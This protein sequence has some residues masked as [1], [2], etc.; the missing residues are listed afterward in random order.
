MENPGASVEAERESG[1]RLRRLLLV[2]FFL[3]GA[4]ALIYQVVWVRMLGLVFGVTSIAVTTVLAAF[5]AG[6]ALGSYVGGRF[7]DRRRD[8]LRIFGFLQ[9]GIGLFAILLP[10]CLEGL[11]AVYVSVYRSWPAD[12]YVFSLMRF[13]LAFGLLL[14]PTSL[15][16][17]TLPVLAR[18]FVRGL[19]E[20]GSGM[21][22]LYSVNNWGAVVG[23]LGAGFVCLELFG[24][25][26]TGWLAAALSIGVGLVAFHLH[27]RGWSLEAAPAGPGEPKEPSPSEPEPGAGG[28]AGLKPYPGYVLVLVLV[29]FGIEGFTSLG[30]EVVWTRILS[31]LGIVT[32]VYT[33]SLVVATFIAGLAIGSFLAGKYLDGRGDPLTLLAVIEVGIGLSAALL[34]PVFNMMG[35]RLAG[36]GVGGWG[37]LVGLVA[38]WTGLLLLVP[39]TLMGA[40]FPLVS[41]IYT[42]NFRELGRRIGKIGC[43]DTVG[44]IFG[45]FAGGFLLIPFVGMHR[46]VLFLA[47]LNVAIG[48]GLLLCHPR[49]RPRWKGAWTAGIAAVGLG[50]LLFLPHEAVFSPH[51]QVPDH[52]V[53]YDEGID[54]TVTVREV[55]HGDRVLE[56]NHTNVAGTAPS[57]VSTQVFQGHMPG[58]IYEALNGRRPKRGLTIGLGTGHTAWCLRQHD[59]EEIHCVE[60]VPGVVEAAKEHFRVLHHGI[61][62]DPRF[63]VSVQD[64]R[65]VL[66]ATDRKYD[67]ILDDAVHPCFGGNA[68]L[69]TTDFFS[70]CRQRL[71]EGGVMT[72]WLPI[73]KLRPDDLRMVLNS[74][75]SVFPHASV[76]FAPRVLN[77]HALLVGTQSEL[78]LDLQTLRRRLTDEAVRPAL[79][80]IGLVNVEALVNCLLLD[81]EG[82]GEFS[83]DAPLHTDNHPYLAFSAPRARVLGPAA[84][85]EN[86]SL[87]ARH[88]A[89]IL[90]HLYHLGQTPDEAA[91]LRE[92]IA[93]QSEATEHLLEGLALH[94]TGGFIAAI[95]EGE[96]ALELRP[97]AP[98][99]R[100][101]L[102]TAHADRAS[103]LFW[104]DRRVGDAFRECRKSLKYDPGNARAATL[105]A[106][107]LAR[108][109]RLEHAIQRLEAGLESSPRYVPA[110]S[111]LAECYARVGALQMARRQAESILEFLP[112]YAPA[113][114]FLRTLREV[115]PQ[116]T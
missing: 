83:G 9:L 74:F 81:A 93:V 101:L 79:A 25:R 43:L 36:G 10:L 71:A 14:V 57:L 60:L 68:S 42:V 50:A 92:K 116:G 3:S 13:A 33:Y 7:I 15:M 23:A 20:V 51:Y 65:T 98:N 107:I 113:H 88:R 77:K 18:F 19:R 109:G 29:V 76:W 106:R 110:M 24:V 78:K 17:A 95:R 84:Y 52:L 112:D 44:S 96:Q 31:A 45:A 61:F 64:A 39:T 97:E 28:A 21:G 69:Y 66:L 2:L 85:A 1:G 40:T 90:P 46:G 89:Q 53:H 87:L 30:Y 104:K 91:A 34:L 35:T 54:A 94:R 16:G 82:I 70:H 59:L 41:R 58:L 75:K 73:Y 11:T 55:F 32:T 48:L 100:A 102:S 4:C 108:D 8:P 80:R 38:L 111:L 26:E 22:A 49:L 12:I 114:R 99:V 67:L 115:G 62:E 27:R 37:Q 103:R 63:H 47:A 6:L 56:V 72:A 86:L 5:M 105:Y